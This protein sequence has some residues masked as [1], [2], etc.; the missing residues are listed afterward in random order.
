MFRVKKKRKPGVFFVDPSDE[1]VSKGTKNTV[2]TFIEME[3]EPVD[4]N[5]LMEDFN[6]IVDISYDQEIKE[7][8]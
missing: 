8:K 1:K 2:K 5:N 7:E 3:N 4:T 6:R